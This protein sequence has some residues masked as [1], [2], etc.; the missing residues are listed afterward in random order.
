MPGVF[1]VAAV[2][3]AVTV[4]GAVTAGSG[5]AVPV[6]TALQAQVV[7]IE[8]PAS[9]QTYNLGK[10]F[11]NLMV[12]VPASNEKLRARVRRIVETA[13]GAPAGE[14]DAALA[15]ADGNAK[16]AIVS[17]LAGIDAAEA[18]ARLEATGGN[19]REALRG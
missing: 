3:G 8:L 17:L 16:A 14:V 15:A 7:D 6:P 13:T 12:D 18:A 4:R 10:T 9:V 1:R 5:Q 19:V 11:D 2:L